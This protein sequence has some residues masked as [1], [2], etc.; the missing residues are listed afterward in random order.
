M[1]NLLD[2]IR[3]N[4]QSLQTQPVAED[5]TQK[6]ESLLRAKS[7][8][9]IGGGA[10]SSSNLQEQQASVQNAGQMQQ[11]AQGANIMQQGQE[12]QFAGQQQ[13]EGIAAK[14]IEQSK[15]FDN[16]QTRLKT[17]QLL[18]DLER[19]KGEIDVNRDVAGLEQV[20]FNLRMQNKEYVDNLQREGNKAR[21]DNHLTFQE[22][23]QKDIFGE[24]ERLIKSQ[25][26]ND[27]LLKE[28]DRIFQRELTHMGVD[29]MFDQYYYEK[30][31]AKKR[32]WSEALGSMIGAG[33]GAASSSSSSS[34]TQ[35]NTSA[36]ERP[37]QSYGQSSYYGSQ[38]G[39]T[40]TTGRT[41]E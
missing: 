32:Q 16:I 41:P 5:Q 15:K 37:A 18:R 25:M 26:K 24:S 17:E 36:R 12:Q 22:A 21:L 35:D 27:N 1:A 2:Q 3:K 20:G 19:N 39:G 8:K 13:R 29:Q 11:I 14:E 9:S 28:N 10:V 6:I 34:S 31:Q 7:G 30:D 40:R 33:A 4:N 23:L 38:E